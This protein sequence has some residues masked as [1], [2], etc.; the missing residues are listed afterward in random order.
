MPDW[1]TGAAPGQEMVTDL[2]PPGRGPL[3][4]LRAG[5]PA[6]HWR[7]CRARQATRAR[8]RGRG[9]LPAQRRPRRTTRSCA[10]ARAGDRRRRHA[11][12][13][14]CPASR[15]REQRWTGSCLGPWPGTTGPLWASWA[16]RPASACTQRSCARVNSR[17]ARSSGSRSSSGTAARRAS[18]WL[19]GCGSSCR[20]WVDYSGRAANVGSPVL[21]RPGG[22]QNAE[23]EPAERSCRLRVR[24]TA[25]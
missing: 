20:H 3:C 8:E 11:R 24:S 5:A 14:S 16:R 9:P 21:A 13:A 25:S 17:S 4:G 2:P 12:G 7:S 23:M 15:R 10:R 6:H 1:M 22:G 18:G 19:S